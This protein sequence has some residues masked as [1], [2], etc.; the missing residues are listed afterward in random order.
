MAIYGSNVNGFQV[1]V[2]STTTG[3]SNKW[4]KIAES[5]SNMTYYDTSTTTLLV[6]VVG[7]EYLT[8]NDTDMSFILHAKMTYDGV[9]TRAPG[10]YMTVEK[11]NH[12][13]TD[14]FDPTTDVFLTWGSNGVYDIW[15]KVPESNKDVFVTH[16]GGSNADTDHSELSAVIT[17]GQS[18]EADKTTLSSGGSFYA[19][20]ANKKF[21]DVTVDTISASTISGT[22]ATNANTANKVVKRDGSGDF[23]ANVITAD[24]AGNISGNAATADAIDVTNDTSSAVHYIPFVATSNTAAGQTLKVNTNFRINPGTEILATVSDLTVM[25]NSTFSSTKG[26]IDP[27][28]IVRT[29]TTNSFNIN[30]TS[31]NTLPGFAVG[32]GGE[33][34]TTR[35]SGPVYIGGGYDL[36]TT[37]V[38]HDNN[39]YNSG[40][41]ADLAIWVR[42]FLDVIDASATPHTLTKSTDFINNTSMNTSTLFDPIK[43]LP[44]STWNGTGNNPITVADH[45][46]FN[47]TDSN[48]LTVAF[49]INIP[50]AA[51]LTAA[52]GHVLASKGSANGNMEWT[53]YFDNDSSAG[54]PALWFIR[55]DESEGSYRGIAY[56]NLGNGATNQWDVGNWVHVAIVDDTTLGVADTV[57]YINGVAVADNTSNIF[58]W[59]P[60]GTYEGSED[61][62]GVLQIG[63]GFAY[64]YATNGLNNG[65]KLAEFAV[66]TDA[67]TAAE[68]AAIYSASQ[69]GRGS[70]EYSTMA[71][72]DGITYLPSTY[73][74]TTS[75]KPNVTIGTAGELIRSTHTN[76]ERILKTN[77]ENLNADLESVC[78]LVP[79]LFNW[80]T[81]PDDKKIPGFIIDEVEDKFPELVVPAETDSDY[82]SLEYDR[83]CAYIVSAMKEIKD[84]LEALESKI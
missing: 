8:S 52:N 48:K 60:A 10:Q 13:G 3:D 39:V 32:C 67:L 9:T 78:K 62:S 80:K 34:T 30:G 69:F 75:N 74:Y 14:S 29:T 43:G 36:T 22:A 55:E 76:S 58:D 4:I 63:G 73:P 50:N 2:N 59:T 24:L 71:F 66:W 65:V 53:I 15:L 79:V 46:D 81:A 21:K 40:G 27:L 82:K 45:S 25:P 1:Q 20:Y 18:W 51:W 31:F 19:T 41:S 7:R 23:E 6:N 77:I 56:E 70:H 54:D 72:V 17:T 28:Q 57:F 42:F 11:L 12:L 35:I 5:T 49:W 83:F 37:F 38:G 47:F 16:L 84:R 44:A 61:L 64:G 33:Q 26:M 68:V